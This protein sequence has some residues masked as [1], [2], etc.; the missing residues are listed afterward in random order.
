MELKQKVI[1]KQKGEKV[2]IPIQNIHIQM[3]WKAAVDLDLHAYYRVKPGSEPQKTG[4]FSKFLGGKEK[5]EGHVYFFRR[6]SRDKFPYIFLDQDA[7]VGDRGGDNQE[8]LYFTN[9]ELM[10]HI[11]IVANIFNK[12]N[13]NFASFD[14]KVILTADGREFEVPLSESQPGSYCII[15]RIDYSGTQPLLVNVNKTQRAEPSISEF[16]GKK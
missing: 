12:P 6:G 5:S 9:L 7:G 4:L 13:A 3:R 1:L 16:A 8:N 10:Q 15:A 11:L 14:G 2:A